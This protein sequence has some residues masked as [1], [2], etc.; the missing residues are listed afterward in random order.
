[1]K[2]RISPKSL[3]R[4]LGILL[5]AVAMSPLG[6]SQGQPMPGMTTPAT[7]TSS[8][9]QAT[10]QSGV[11]LAELEQMALSNN[12]TLAQAAAE[13]HAATGRKLQS[14]LYP[15]PTVGYLG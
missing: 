8:Q 14:G 7:T 5:A 15:N 9:E 11:T 10:A 2:R 6:F 13:I 3:A 4:V 12:P 1:M